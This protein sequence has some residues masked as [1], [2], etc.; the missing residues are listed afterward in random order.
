MLKSLLEVLVASSLRH[1]IEREV[2]KTLKIFADRTL[3]VIVCALNSP[4][5]RLKME[6]LNRRVHQIHQESSA[7]LPQRLERRGIQ[8][9]VVVVLLRSVRKLLN[10]FCQPPLRKRI[11]IVCDV[12]ELTLDAIKLLHH[13]PDGRFATLPYEVSLFLIHVSPSFPSHE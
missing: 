1:D 11:D 4:L 5:E 13:R 12:S 7:S 10:F 6:P 8:N 9:F 3:P 2:L